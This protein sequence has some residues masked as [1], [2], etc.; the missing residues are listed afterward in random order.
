[1]H[2]ALLVALNTIM[3]KVYLS[4][5]SNLGNKKANLIEAIKLINSE[6]GAINSV[7][8]I[9]ESEA[10]GFKSDNSFYNMALSVATKLNKTDLLQH[11]QDIEKKT[12]KNT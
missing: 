6:I 4:L 5:G 12:R 7:S 3:N 11:C 10:W 8:S 9:Y 2:K 1:M